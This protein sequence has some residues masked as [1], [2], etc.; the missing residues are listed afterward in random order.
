[1]TDLPDPSGPVSVRGGIGP[2]GPIPTVVAATDRCIYWMS[3][4]IVV[5]ALTFLFLAILINVLLRYLF[6]AGITWAYEIPSIL[7]PWV[8]V[9]G[10]VMAAQAGRHI[11]VVALLKLLPGALQRLLLIAVNLLIAV[12]A[13]FVVEAALPIIRA[14]HSSHLAE[15]GI[16][17]SYGYASLI[18]GFVMIG[19]TALTTAYRLAFA[20]EPSE[21]A[22]VPGAQA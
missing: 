18:Y 20:A 2:G 17:Q 7:F 16:A 21:P 11:A 19:L 15:T 13:A 3:A 14:A 22:G 6:A 10:A 12:A 1:M 4:A 8:V 5:S 9:A